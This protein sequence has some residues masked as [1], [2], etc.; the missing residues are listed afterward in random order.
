MS[1]HL[2]KR[3]VCEECAAEV[4]CT[5]AGNGSFV[6]CDKEMQIKQAQPLP[7]SD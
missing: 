2:G 1:N 5:K 3:Y 4:L 6:C 7:S